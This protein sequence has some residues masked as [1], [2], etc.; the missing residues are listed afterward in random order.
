MKTIAVYIQNKLLSSGITHA[1]ASKKPKTTI[2][3]IPEIESSLSVCRSSNADVLLAEIRDYSPLSL[4]NWLARAKKI[5]EVVPT[6]KIVLV[7]DEESF[8]KSA[9]VAN[10][11]FKNEEID[12][13]LYST[14][15]LNYL[16][17]IVSS[18]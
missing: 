15:G 3:L 1:I 14:S 16:V 6:C 18:L 11:A 5:K 8:P 13:F 10:S 17:D 7:V 12:M 2:E 9:S 4:D